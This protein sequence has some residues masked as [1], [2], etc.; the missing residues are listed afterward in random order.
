MVSVDLWEYPT[1]FLVINPKNRLE[2]H[3]LILGR[4]WLATEDAYISCQTGSMM[5]SRGNSVK[6]IFIYPPAKPSLPTIKIHKH[7]ETYWEHNIRPPLMLV[8]ALEF[9][10]QTEDDMITNVMN[11]PPRPENLKCQMMKNIIGHEGQETL[12]TDFEIQS[13]STDTV[14]N[15]IPI[16]I[17]PSKILNINNNLD[18]SQR[19]KLVKILRKHQGAFAWDYKDMKGLGP[20]LCIHHIYIDKDMSLVRQPQKRL[21]PHLK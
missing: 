21:N 16:E 12:V 2:G 19:Q 6:K 13:D 1:D 8:E 3:P 5:I 7:P 4:P 9:K 14:C 10:N 17:E 11:Q 18:D 15:S 20:Q